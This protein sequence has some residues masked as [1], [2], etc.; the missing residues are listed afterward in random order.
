M[1][2]RRQTVQHEPVTPMDGARRFLADGRC[3]KRGRAERQ[4]APMPIDDQDMP[5]R[6]GRP[7][8]LGLERDDAK[9]GEPRFRI[10]RIWAEE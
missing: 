3:R 2:E 5:E 4:V 1:T 10:V 6:T 9:A 7:E 8:R